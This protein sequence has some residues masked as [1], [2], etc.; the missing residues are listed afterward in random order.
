M[1][2]LLLCHVERRDAATNLISFIGFTFLSNWP[3]H[4]DEIYRYTFATPTFFFRGSYIKSSPLTFLLRKSGEGGEAQS[5]FMQLRIPTNCQPSINSSRSNQLTALMRQFERRRYLF[6][7]DSFEISL[8]IEQIPNLFTCTLAKRT[9][10][11]CRMVRSQITSR[12]ELLCWFNEFNG[13]WEQT[14]Y[15]QSFQVL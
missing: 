2:A 9:I 5:C 15:F 6:T 7:F 8:R 10:I 14:Y 12:I 1:E 4:G 13:Q 3:R 11:Y